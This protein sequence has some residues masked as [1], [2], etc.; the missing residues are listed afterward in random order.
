MYLC[1]YVCMYS[2]LVA[3]TLSKID[4]QVLLKIGSTGATEN[5]F[6]KRYSELVPKVL[7][8]IDPPVLLKI[9]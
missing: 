1:I 4:S 9:D 8:K 2:K 7:L 6:L 3:Q 5:W